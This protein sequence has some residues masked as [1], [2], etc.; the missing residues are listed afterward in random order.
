VIGTSLETPSNCAARVGRVAVYLDRR[1]GRGE[2]QPC[3]R[4][5]YSR[6]NA[7]FCRGLV[8]AIWII[9]VFLFS[10]LASNPFIYFQF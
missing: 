7:N 1:R 6:P 10:S 8:F 5:L 9:G 2:T 4:S 3:R